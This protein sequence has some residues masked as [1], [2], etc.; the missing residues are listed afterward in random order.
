MTLFRF[1]IKYD[2]IMVW[3]TVSHHLPYSNYFAL[4]LYINNCAFLFSSFVPLVV[5]NYLLDHVH[6]NFSAMWSVVKFPIVLHSRSV[7]VEV[8]CCLLIL[9]PTS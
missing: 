7:L 5:I 1:E 4:H 3:C 8:N 2:V 9:C 6:V